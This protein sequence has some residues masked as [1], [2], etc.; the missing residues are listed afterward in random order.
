[1]YITSVPYEAGFNQVTI[2]DDTNL[3]VQDLINN[4]GF[5]FIVKAIIKAI[6]RK[7]LDKPMANNYSK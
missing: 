2:Y 3:Y 6:F 5:R 1:M 4:N 7:L